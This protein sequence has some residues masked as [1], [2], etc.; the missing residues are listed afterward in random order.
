M[1]EKEVL[2]GLL[3][4]KKIAILK[5]LYFAKEEMYLREI[6]KKSKVSVSSVF[7]ILSELIRIGL[8][9][10]KEVGMMKFFSLVRDGRSRFL[11]DWFKEESLLDV[12]VEEIKGMEGLKKVI[13]HGKVEE[14][15]ASII[16]IGEGIDGRMVEGISD[17]IKEKGFDVSYLVLTEEQ[18]EKLDKMGLYGGEKKV[19]L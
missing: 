4:H 3:D 2:K 9:R 12:F 17:E 11:E 5:V 15:R 10:V 6:A 8:V 16:L 18:F 13:L 19:L 14:N 1:I 7:R